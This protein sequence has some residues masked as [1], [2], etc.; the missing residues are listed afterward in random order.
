MLH[1]I[2]QE[3][4]KFLWWGLS[5]IVFLALIGSAVNNW[6][7]AQNSKSL[8]KSAGGITATVFDAQ[9]N[10][11]AFYLSADGSPNM[12]TGEIIEIAGKKFTPYRMSES[13]DSYRVEWKSAKG[14]QSVVISKKKPNAELYED[15]GFG[16][17]LLAV[18]EPKFQYS[19]QGWQN[20]QLDFS[21]ATVENEVNETFSRINIGFT[22]ID[23]TGRSIPA[24]LSVA[25]GF[26]GTKYINSWEFYLSDNPNNNRLV[27]D[28]EHDREKLAEYKNNQTQS[29]FASVLGGASRLAINRSAGSEVKI[30]VAD[31]IKQNN[32]N[33]KLIS[34]QEGE[35]YFYPNGQIG[36]MLVDPVLTSVT[37]DT[38]ITISTGSGTTGDFKLFFS[39]SSGGL[40]QGFL[41]SAGWGGDLLVNPTNS[42]LLT[43]LN[44]DA[45]AQTSTAST[46]RLLEASSTRAVVRN[47]F[48]L[49]SE[50]SV[51]EDYYIY[52]SGKIVKKI[53][54]T[55]LD[56]G[57]EVRYVAGGATNFVI[58]G[59][60]GYGNDGGTPPADRPI[61]TYYDTQI[62]RLDVRSASSDEITDYQNPDMDLGILKGAS[63][64]EDATTTAG[65]NTWDGSYGVDL[66]ATDTAVYISDLDGGTQTRYDPVFKIRGWSS[67]STPN[68]VALNGT[69]LASGTNYN[70]SLKP[71]SSA[72]YATDA[73]TTTLSAGGDYASSTEFLASSLNNKTM[74]F[75]SGENLYLGFEMPVS[76]V[77]INLATAG[78]GGTVT[79]QYCSAVT[80]GNC[81]TWSALTVN[82]TVN[83]INNFTALSGSVYF[84][85]PSNWAT[86]TA[87][88]ITYGPSVYY[89]RIVGNGS[90]A[91]SPVE[92]T[93]WS[94]VLVF[95]YL[96][97]I[98]T[99]NNSFVIARASKMSAGSGDIN[100]AG[101]WSPSG[102][103]SA[104]DNILIQNTHSVTFV[105]SPATV[106]IKNLFI[107]SGGSFVMGVT[108]TDAT[109]TL[110]GSLIASGNFEMRANSPGSNNY[111]IYEG[112]ST[113]RLK[114][115]SAGENGVIVESSG[116]MSLR[117]PTSIDIHEGRAGDQRGIKITRFGSNNG[118]IY[119]KDGAEAIIQNSEIAYMG[120]NASRKYGIYADA[121][122]NGTAN[123]GLVVTGSIIDNGYD[124]IYLSGSTDVIVSD[125]RIF[126]NSNNGI[127]VATTSNSTFYANTVWFN[128]A[129]GYSF[130]NGDSNII[131]NNTLDAN[132]TSVLFDTDS[133][134]NTIKNSIIILN[135]TGLTNNGTSNTIDYNLFNSNTSDGSVGTNSLSS[136]VSVVDWNGID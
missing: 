50:A 92:S 65:F 26:D 130:I 81:S 95:Q 49:G 20:Y 68:Y 43:E 124:G 16:W 111:N 1:N 107:A 133:S 19:T 115:A 135:T 100:T 80:S 72:Y 108:T 32:G 18:A 25:I 99:N 126:A 23:S 69:T 15:I 79:W 9:N 46:L 75:A 74:D 48:T 7:L 112:F 132:V 27:W 61:G 116:T 120:A 55:K 98:T 89:L 12:V 8:K 113:L 58:A 2:Q 128:G 31:F 13:K 47:S 41:G 40:D 134:S 59:G 87:D 77:N 70:A 101:T 33:E 38:N 91:P 3:L 45:S 114:S 60:S 84:D 51:V 21:D 85:T 78:V 96:G 30:S 121:I 93:I 44:Q 88:S 56:T 14:T 104:T 71:I 125:N 34:Q 62:I 136:A 122:D 11:E 76:G 103:P 52:S 54:Y 131:S 35:Y 82:S 17:E 127:T 123:E 4:K 53:V 36:E 90:Y 64:E 129:T 73:A 83:G 22:V 6:Q 97:N 39:Q 118:F 63:L 37:A 110:D 57:T 102:V 24:S 106:N 66:T 86:S 94:D 117:G 109:T 105:N 119:L 28:I 42:V 67:I 10:P 29:Y 5:V